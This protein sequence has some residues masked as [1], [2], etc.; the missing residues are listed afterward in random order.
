M[1]DLYSKHIKSLKNKSE[2]DIIKWNGL[3]SS[4]INRINVKIVKMKILPKAIHRH[5][6]ILTNI[7]SR[8]FTDLKRTI[9]NFI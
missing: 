1:K 3:P 9:V 6:A 8:L 5:K 2:E 7:P 4:C